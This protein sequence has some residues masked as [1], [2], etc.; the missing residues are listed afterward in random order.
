MG[1]SYEKQS[2]ASHTTDIKSFIPVARVDRKNCDGKDN[3][4][5]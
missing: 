1:K 5:T 2:D 4:E 3:T